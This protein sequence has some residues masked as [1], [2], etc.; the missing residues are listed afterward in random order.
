M[1]N[2]QAKACAA[3]ESAPKWLQDA[4]E[5]LRR[6]PNALVGNHERDH[7]GLVLLG[8]DVT[9]RERQRAAIRHRPQAIGRKIPHDLPDLRFVREAPDRLRWHFTAN[10]VRLEPLRAVLQQRARV[11]TALHR[12][13]GARRPAARCRRYKARIAGLWRLAHLAAIHR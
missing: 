13:G 5:L 6:Y 9:R 11:E 1:N 10:G 8:R 12:N 2:R 7:L 4:V 3:L